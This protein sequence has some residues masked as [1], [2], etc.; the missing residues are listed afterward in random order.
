MSKDRVLALFG[1]LLNWRRK[2]WGI[3]DAEEA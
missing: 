2:A 3:G 1:V